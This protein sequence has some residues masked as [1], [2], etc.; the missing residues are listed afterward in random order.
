MS[1]MAGVHKTLKW[2]LAASVGAVILA[3][4]WM[5]SVQ[6]LGRAPLPPRKHTPCRTQTS[7]LPPP[8]RLRSRRARA[9]SRLRAPPIPPRACLT[10]VQA[11]G[12]GLG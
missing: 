4:C 5:A 12:L 8:A 6:M 7:P 10:L 11:L 1:V 9:R 3:A 2:L